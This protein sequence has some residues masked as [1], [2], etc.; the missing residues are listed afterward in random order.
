[1]EVPAGSVVG[2]LGPNGCGKSTLLKTVYRALPPSTG[3][4]LLDEQDA[5]RDMTARQA[6]TRVAA[7]A[8]EAGHDSDFSVLQ[9]VAMGRTPHQ[10]GWSRETSKD[11]AVVRSALQ[12]VGM[13]GH[14]E[15]AFAGLSG[16]EK[17]PCCPCPRAWPARPSMRG[18]HDLNLAAAYCDELYLMRDGQ[19]SGAPQ[20]AQ[21][22]RDCPLAAPHL[23]LSKGAEQAGKALSRAFVG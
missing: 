19:P 23:P 8:Q 2:L 4:V 10:T 21:S 17:Q 22:P 18:Q 6:A 20:G 12:T 3:V 7:V 11:R 16:G 9:V 14:A 1:V 5:L 13:D 15:R